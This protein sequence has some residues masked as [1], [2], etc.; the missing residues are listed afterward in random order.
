[1]N[2]KEHL[3]II[4]INK[5]DFKRLKKEQKLP[6]ILQKNISQTKK[7]QVFFAMPEDFFDLAKHLLEHLGVEFVST[8]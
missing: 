1:M 6:W 4:A 5:E 3:L 2:K 8:F 7:S